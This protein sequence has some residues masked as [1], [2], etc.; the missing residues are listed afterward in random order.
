[1]ISHQLSPS[2]ANLTWFLPPI[3]CVYEIVC[4]H[5]WM[6][7]TGRYLTME[8]ERRLEMLLSEDVP[9]SVILTLDSGELEIIYL[10]TTAM[11]KCAILMHSTYL[12]N[13]RKMPLSSIMVMDG[14]GRGQMI[15]H[16]KV[17]LA[18]SSGFLAGDVEPTIQPMTRKEHTTDPRN[19]LL[20][21]KLSANV[22]IATQRQHQLHVCHCQPQREFHRSRDMCPYASYRV[23]LGQGTSWYDMIWIDSV[24]LQKYMTNKQ[25]TCM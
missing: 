10:Q 7:S 24:K 15:A 19:E 1:M 8:E 14:N 2:T 20:K 12:C 11:K 23:L 17:F 6:D 22:Q 18:V 16:A 13:N 5:R 4:G 9:S 3:D 25:W 21:F